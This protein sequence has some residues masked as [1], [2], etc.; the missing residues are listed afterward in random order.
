[1]CTAAFQAARPF[2]ILLCLLP[3]AH[4]DIL[5]RDI[6]VID[7]AT[8]SAHPKRS[9]LIHGDKIAAIGARLPASKSIQIV[10]GTGKYIIPG[11]W[12]MSVHLRDRDQLAQ[13]PAYGITS[14]R[15]MGSDFTRV[16][17]WRAEIKSGKL[18]GP[19]VKTCGPAIDGFP[20]QF[21]WLPVRLIRSP[22][23]ARA[24]FDNLDD[25]NVDFFGIL[26][27]LPRDAY[28]ALIERARKWYS[29]VA[30]D[31]PATVSAFEAVDARQRSIDHMSGILLAC[32]SEERRLREPRSLA[33]ER[34]DREGFDFAE[35]VALQTFSTQKADLLFE[36]M[37]RFETR[38]VPTLVKLRALPGEKDIYPKLAQLLVRMHRAGVGILS[39]SDNEKSEALHDELEL[40]VAA[41]LTPA[42]ALR[43]ATIEPAKFFDTTETM[44]SV[45]KGKAADLVLLDA[46]PLTDIR[47]TRKISGVIVAGKYLP[48][49]RLTVIRAQAKAAN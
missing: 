24:A 20:S 36:R 43:S 19:A 11:L 29:S 5:I 17:E 6:T 3:P 45:D 26:P 33:L 18:L 42:D 46:D 35:A 39:G 14:V 22:N 12:D 16:K 15:D 38:A 10:D 49:A 4:S 28:F 25:Q 37:A 13:Y 40:L 9:I 21:P 32:S 1:M 41:G 27:R 44:G 2:L 30:G 31:V 7:V 23:D 48:K 8:N 47:N 34:N